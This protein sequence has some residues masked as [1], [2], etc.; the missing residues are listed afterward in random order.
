MHL[1]TS[2]RSGIGLTRLNGLDRTD[3]IKLRQDERLNRRNEGLAKN[4]V[5]ENMEAKMDANL[6]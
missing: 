2:V 6:K 5:Q 3:S 4:A 1:T